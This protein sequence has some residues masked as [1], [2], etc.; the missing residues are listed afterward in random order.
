[1]VCIALPGCKKKSE[2]AL[3]V[4]RNYT[5]IQD[6]DG[7]WVEKFD[8]TITDEDRYNHNNVI[9]KVGRSFRY[10]Y[11]YIDANGVERKFIDY[12]ES[13][14]FSTPDDASAVQDVTI[15]VLNGL[16]PMINNNPDYNQTVL[17]Y[18]YTNGNWSSS[19]GAIENEKNVWI[20]PPRDNL[21][22]VLEF[23]P[24]PYIQTPYEKGN[25]WKWDLTIG[26]GW[27]DERW[28]IFE[29]SIHNAY[30]YTIAD[31]VN[32]PTPLGELTCYKIESTATSRIGSTYLEAYFNESFGFVTLDYTNIDGSKL[33]MELI[34]VK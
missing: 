3:S 8:S 33:L 16:E 15:S 18:E 31:V 9:Y 14:E 2:E 23:N 28:K 7:I 25:S 11:Q 24:F 29:G 27:G 20:H 10:T 12:G 6:D 1:V 32:K 22:R 26:S 4:A 19:S 21:F 30:D 5:L 13:W 34:E 17:R